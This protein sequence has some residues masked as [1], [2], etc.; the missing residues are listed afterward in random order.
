MV[1][2]VAKAGLVVGTAGVP[3]AQELPV[4]PAV[5]TAGKPGDVEDALYI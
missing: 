2:E 5:V 4:E 1:A 3:S